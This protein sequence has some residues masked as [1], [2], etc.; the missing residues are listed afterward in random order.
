MQLCVLPYSS[1]PLTVGRPCGCPLLENAA[2]APLAQRCQCRKVGW[3]G[4][5]SGASQIVR[6]W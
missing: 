4:S 1:R 5:L 6:R 3:E 2:R